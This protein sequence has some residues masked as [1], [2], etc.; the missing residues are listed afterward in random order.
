MHSG[1][2]NSESFR[3]ENFSQGAAPDPFPAGYLLVSSQ[4][5]D[6]DVDDL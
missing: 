4:T 3:G 5:Y 6:F 1:S 2:S